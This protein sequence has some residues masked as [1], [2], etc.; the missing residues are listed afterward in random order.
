MSSV[1]SRYDR[2]RQSWYNAASV[3]ETHFRSLLSSSASREWKRVSSSAEAS[4]IVKGKARASATPELNDIV[5]HRKA[6]KNGDN[7]YRAVL[8][9]AAGESDQVSLDYWKAV[10]STPELRQVW[11][12][13]VEEAHTVEMLDAVTRITKTK[14]TLG[15]PAK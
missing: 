9:V 4:A 6:G 11:D 13:A 12:P 10:I 3:A 14:Y 15:W 7:T 5:V 1:Y 8:D 2:L